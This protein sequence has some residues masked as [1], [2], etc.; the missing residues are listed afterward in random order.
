MAEMFCKATWSQVKAGDVVLM[1]WSDLYEVVEV[2]VL[3][4]E[5]EEARTDNGRRILASME[6]AGA[7]FL[8]LPFDPNGVAYVKSRF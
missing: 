1:P 8:K 7:Q 6:I 2:P 3:A 4:V 5:K